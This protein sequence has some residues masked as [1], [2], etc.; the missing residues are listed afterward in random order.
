MS[1]GTIE[2]Y[3]TP[4]CGWAVRNYAALIEKGVA[5]TIVMAKDAGGRKTDEF[6]ALSPYARTPVMAVDGKTVW[7]SL[8]MNY[9]ID[10]LFPEP[11]LMPDT[12]VE[13]ARARLW[14]RHCDHELFPA[15]TGLQSAPAADIG[16]RVE[17]GLAQLL[18]YGF[19]DDES[20]DFWMGSRIGLVDMCYATLF[21]SLSVITAMN[22]PEWLRIPERLVRWRDAINAHPTIQQ[23]QAVP[24]T[25]SL[26]RPSTTV[27]PETGETFAGTR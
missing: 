7:D 24:E 3:S 22:G 25:L 10:E 6:L 5:F 11:A 1:S 9:F 19:Q 21:D 14:M 23:A 4:G 8:Q 20:G 18:E 27:L 12:P 15:I 16:E 2:I 26:D 13:R 17:T